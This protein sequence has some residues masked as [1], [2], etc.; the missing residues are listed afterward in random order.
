MVSRV[1]EESSPRVS[2]AGVVL[3]SL[4]GP[5]VGVPTGA[6][7]EL[8]LEQGFSYTIQV[9]CPEHTPVSA[10]LVRTGGE[11]G[12]RV[13]DP[14]LAGT[15]NTVG[16]GLLRGHLEF[17]LCPEVLKGRGP[18]CL[19]V[20]RRALHNRPYPPRCLRVVFPDYAPAST[21]AFGAVEIRRKPLRAVVEPV[22]GR[23][24]R[25]GPGETRS[26]LPSTAAPAEEDGAPET[27]TP[28]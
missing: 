8:T 19:G 6:L 14:M 21:W 26:W 13:L 27:K 17:N 2:R 28:R 7:L 10:R 1:R 25:T 24:A 23:L 16:Q 5:S 9:T 12:A 18:I 15:W 3:V 11:L 20:G 22:P 4:D